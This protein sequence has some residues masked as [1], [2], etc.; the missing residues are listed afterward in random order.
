MGLCDKRLLKYS[1][2]NYG[3]TFTNSNRYIN[4]VDG[5]T[6]KV[7]LIPTKSYT[8]GQMAN[9]IASAMNAVGEQE[10]IVTLDRA[11]RSFTISAPA[12]FQLL[13]DSGTN[14]GQSAY[15]L[16][17]FTGADLTG[18]NSYTGGASGDQYITQTPLRNF[19]D[20]EKNK[21]KL[22]AVVRKTPTNVREAISYGT[23][24]KMK[25]EFPLIT[26]ITGQGF[27]RDTA[28]G[29]EEADDL[30]VY[31]IDQKPVE[32]LE[33]VENPLA[34]T[35]CVLDKTSSSQ[36]G[37]GFE[38]KPLTRRKLPGYFEIKGLVFSEIEV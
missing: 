19:S 33:S 32:F 25:C 5:V 1:A 37:T 27:M 11:T 18:T 12:N 14:A 34:F 9:V 38:M 21:A 29:V 31:L 6:E 23:E 30:M 13:V 26:N 7:A 3:H 15:P 22:D 20:F 10:Y 28:T 36:N 35:S 4:F 17:G 16:L 8:L 2:F 24:K